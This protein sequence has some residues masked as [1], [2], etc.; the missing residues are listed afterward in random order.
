LVQE[1]DLRKRGSPDPDSFN[2]YGS[3]GG[4]MES[5]LLLLYP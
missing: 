5:F 4:N 3:N 1:S 2:V